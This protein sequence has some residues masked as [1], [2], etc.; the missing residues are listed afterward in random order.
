MSRFGYL[1]ALTILLL[2]D[3]V[4]KALFP[5]FLTG[6]LSDFA[7]VFVLAVFLAAFVPRVPACIAAG[8]L[9]VWWKSPLS[10]PFIAVLPWETTR[11]EYVHLA[12][13]TEYV[14][15][16]IE[17]DALYVDRAAWNRTSLLNIAR[18]GKFSSDRTIREYARD[19]W[20][21]Q[22]AVIGNFAHVLE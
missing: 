14:E 3:H 18:M 16:Q 6:K 1:V 21:I 22:P 7:G 11:D 10:D 2:N 5:G 8:L 17:V 20:D 13:L 4:L 15:R 9:F 12:D 19:I